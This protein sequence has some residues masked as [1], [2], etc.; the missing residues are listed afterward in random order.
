MK[1]YSVSYRVH[2]YKNICNCKK[3]NTYSRAY[4]S[5]VVSQSTANTCLRI[6]IT[7]IRVSRGLIA[8][9][10]TDDI[11][12]M[13]FHISGN[14]VIMQGDSVLCRSRWPLGLKRRSAAAWFLGLR[15]RIP[16]RTSKDR[17]R[18]TGSLCSCRL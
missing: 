8:L 17:F 13:C 7:R 18:R 16:L 1:L 14:N 12:K 10:N 15:F 2:K 6:R 5:L 4:Y 11:N 3:N 9:V